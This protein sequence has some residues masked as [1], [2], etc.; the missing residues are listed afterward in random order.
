MQTAQ[1]SR[2]HP[3]AIVAG[4]LAAVALLFVVAIALVNP[5]AIANH[6]KDR[7]LPQISE[8]LGRQVSIADVH[9]SLFP[10]GATLTDM[11]VAGGPNEPALISAPEA[12]ASVK[13]WPLLVSGGHDIQVR[14]IE[15]RNPTIDLVRRAN[16]TWSYEDL[17]RARGTPAAKA[18]AAPANPPP[19]GNTREAKAEE[20]VVADIHVKH[21]TVR[22]IEE[23]AGR[24]AATVALSQLD[25]DAKNVGPGRP[26]QVSL[27]G[28]LA[29]ATQN[30]D[31]KLA[32]DRLPESGAE[33]QNGPWPKVT[34]QVSLEPLE[35]A[36]VEKLAPELAGVVSGGRVKVALHIT[37]DQS[38][39]YATTGDATIEQLS[40]RG[41]P[42]SGSFHIDGSMNPRLTNSMRAQLS[43]LRL[44][45]PGIDLGGTVSLQAPAHVR[46]ALNGSQLDVDTLIGHLPSASTATPP[47]S[48]SPAR[49]AAP[50]APTQPSRAHRTSTADIGGTLTLGKVTAGKLHAENLKTQMQLAR[51]VFVLTEGTATLYSGQA[52]LSGTSVDMS[53][54]DPL[55][56]L[57]AILQG[58]DLGA[59]M[60]DVHGKA[61]ATGQVS[62]DLALEG[63]GSNWNELRTNLNGNGSI[64]LTNG[65][66]PATNLGAQIV[67]PLSVALQS[68]GMGSSTGK[69]PLQGGTPV[70]DLSARFEVKDGWMEFSQPLAFDTSLGSMSLTGRIGLDQRL[71]LQGH[72][73]LS[74]TLMSDMTLGR[75]KPNAPVDVPIRIGGTLEAAR[76]E[77]VDWGSIAKS[78]LV[79]QLQQGVQKSLED[80]AKQKLRGILGGS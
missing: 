30:L 54:P 75:F 15:L 72:A 2:R 37:T 21:G 38:G 32:F 49:T 43:R 63:K 26:A 11:S 79:P 62:G 61:T 77:G 67:Q 4:V 47:P 25:L 3:L 13:L 40:M 28:A 35:L 7:Y 42:A 50:A 20:I 17:G 53:A 70:K 12:R 76:V 8:Q 16:G 22:V 27:K 34:G 48:G 41:A 80:Q 60:K 45:G 59:A 23:A 51:G 73:I 18:P 68:L 9:V 69:V 24:P 1:H 78:V 58:L 36:S 10:L 56:T 44:Q 19:V 66:L 14:A 33:L 57:K 46:F 52:S 6:V 29:S 74:Q 64:A 71:D 39:A 65:E 5:S 55:W 31:V